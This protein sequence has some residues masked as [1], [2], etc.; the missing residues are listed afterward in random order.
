VPDDRFSRQTRFA[1]FGAR[2][3]EN[4]G[5]AT[6]AVVGLGGLGSWIAEHLARAGVGTLR[7]IDRDVVEE[8]NL[9]RQG[10][11]VDEDARRARPKA[12]AAA[13]R[14]AAIG[15]PT[16]LEPLVRELT[17]RSAD[18]LLGPADLVVDGLDAFAPRF[19][20]NDWCRSKRKPWVYGGALAGTGS[21]LL[22]AEGGPCLRCLFPGAD[23]LLGGETCETAGVFSPLTAAIGALEAG[24]ALRWLA[25]D[26]R[27]ARL[28]QVE[29]WDG[30]LVALDPGSPSPDCPVCA[31]RSYPALERDDDEATTK[32][33]GRDTVQ[34]APESGGRALDL[35]L[36]V[37][38]WEGLGT[39][40]RTRFLARLHLGTGGGERG[41]AGRGA[42]EGG[43][44]VTVFDDGR[45]LVRGT[46]SVERARATY[47][48]Y[49]GH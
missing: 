3:Q 43:L 34:V 28:L 44:V 12:E 49:V 6:V 30:R 42:S 48:R 38:R 19:L 32:L 13:E 47:A 15:G 11:Y 33:C 37:K 2:G 46:T 29:P 45:A 20:L 40:E 22:I 27:P 9:P 41:G 7:L 36:L 18:A 8:S 17:S 24:E 16:R 31:G 4:A 23:G 26:R 39:I 14:L 1:P 21:V 10:L 35:D 25:G 5:R